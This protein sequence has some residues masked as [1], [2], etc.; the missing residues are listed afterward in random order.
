[1]ARDLLKREGRYP[2]PRKIPQVCQPKTD[3][4]PQSSNSD[5][6]LTLFF[7]FK[8]LQIPES[9]PDVHLVK[10][11][12]KLPGSDATSSQHGAGSKAWRSQGANSDLPGLI[13]CCRGD[14]TVMDRK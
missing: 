13:D 10:F 6:L 12:I 5:D 3:W 2:R 9:H 1:M 11:W 4:S 8:S 7:P 14:L